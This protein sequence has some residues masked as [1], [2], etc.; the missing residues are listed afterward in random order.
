MA[1]FTVLKNR[2]RFGEKSWP[3]VLLVFVSLEVFC[4]RLPE[5]PSETRA[6]KDEEI[7]LRL[8]CCRRTV[9]YTGVSSAI[10]RLEWH[11]EVELH[12]K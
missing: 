5:F 3:T 11:L 1:G 9:G 12:E 10:A 6:R 2:E 7:M 8:G 4:L